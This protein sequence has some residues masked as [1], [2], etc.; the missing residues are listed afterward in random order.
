[1]NGFQLLQESGR[2]RPFSTI[3]REWRRRL[4]RCWS[5]FLITS[6]T[7]SSLVDVVSF[8]SSL[9]DSFACSD[10]C[11]RAFGV[12]EEAWSELGQTFP[13]LTGFRFPGKIFEAAGIFG[14][15][16]EFQRAIFVSNK[17]MLFHSDGNMILVGGEPRAQ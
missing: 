7:A 17:A 10:Q 2:A 14:E 8:T 11:D 16:V 5:R 9:S 4:T 3:S 12:L 1:M 6:I 13:D 15:I